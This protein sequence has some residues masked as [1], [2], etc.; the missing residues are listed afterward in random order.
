MSRLASIEKAGYFPCPER[1]VGQLIRECTELN[2]ANGCAYTILDPCAGEG[3]A[4]NVLRYTLAERAPSCTFGITAVELDQQRAAAA[5]QLLGHDNVLHGPWENVR[6]KNAAVFN[7]CW[8]NPPYDQYA[9]GRTEVEWVQSVGPLAQVIF[10]VVPEMFVGTGKH[11]ERMKSALRDAG[12]TSAS[13]YRFPDP[14]YD[15]FHQVI[16][17]AYKT[18]SG[19]YGWIDL[20]LTGVIGEDVKRFSQYISGY[21]NQKPREVPVLGMTSPKLRASV[22]TSL[23][24]DLLGDPQAGPA[25]LRPLAPMRDTHAAAMAAAGAFNGAPI[26][27]LVVK[28][29]TI[30][31]VQM[32]VTVEDN[33]REEVEKEVLAAQ[34]STLNMHTGEISTVNSI[35]NAEVFDE[36]IMRHA[37]EFMRLAQDM[38][39]PRFEEA[40]MLRY[41][42]RLSHI[43]A[44]RKLAGRQNGVY[45]A[46]ALRV[47]AILDGWSR[48]KVITL[49]GKQGVGK[50]L[51]ALAACTVKARQRSAHNQ[52]IVVLLPAKDD[53]ARKWMEEAEAALKEYKPYVVHATKISEVQKAFAKQGLVYIFIKETMAKQTSGW[54]SVE[55]TPARMG[56][57]AYLPERCP[58]CG[59]ALHLDTDNPTRKKAHCKGCSTPMWT[60]SRRTNGNGRKKGNETSLGDLDTAINVYRAILDGWTWSDV[61]VQRRKATGKD[62]NGSTVYEI[63]TETMRRAEWHKPEFRLDDPFYSEKTVLLHR[64]IRDSTPRTWADFRLPDEADGYARH[65]LARYIRDHYA[66]QYGL[67]IDESHSFKAADSARA[68]A[69]ND[70]LTSAAFAV[71]MTGT[72][73]NGMA[74][75]I[76]YLLWRA[77][78]AFRELWGWNDV[79]DFVAKYGLS[80]RVTTSKT[81]DTW[82]SKG[83]YI[84][85]SERVEEIPG[86]HPAMIGLLLPTTV[87]FDLS[88]LDEALPS[89]EE[90]TLFVPRPPEMNRV[91][92]YLDDVKTEAVKKMWEGDR[93]LL[94]QWAWGQRGVWDTVSEGDE[95]GDFT[96]AP[97]ACPGPMWPKEE[98]LLRFIWREKQ[99]GRKVLVYVGQINRRDPTGKLLQLMGRYGIKADV[100]RSDEDHRVEFMQKA[101]G[102]GA[103]AVM[104][105]AA[106]V[107]EGIDLIEFATIAWYTA[108]SNLYLIMQANRRIYRIGQTKNALIAYFAYDE[109]PQ[110]ADMDRAARKM[111]AAQMVQG[112][113]RSGLAA[114]LGEETFVSR[115]QEAT[116]AYEHRESSLTMDDLPPLPAPRR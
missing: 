115:L 13:V 109:T 64:F 66:N 31:K 92:N 24:K 54:A 56:K 58:N 2:F 37:P 50:T 74:S 80:Q 17:C 52:K 36:M 75:S 90:V 101:L 34:L 103:D 91:Q 25:E 14:E 4:V 114:I 77:D 61:P 44:P 53:L 106:L 112:D 38:Y 32:F 86:V 111:G 96:L 113:M 35:D 102:S 65:P 28:G 26:G 87:F 73:Y 40:D 7:L 76:Y 62:A 104:T 93:S 48:H 55:G 99:L 84:Q 18:S 12:F 33:V 60:V 22:F 98:A 49:A 29:S 51:C 30:K 79:N 110:A 71:Q 83:G 9:G 19:W 67:V 21:Y 68:L 47:G 57:K 100:M 3:N 97:I 78:P 41:A 94:G 46:Q 72:P 15:A 69:S 107:K 8:L 89:Y 85:S 42:E 70:L 11:A 43:H 88:D 6:R 23:A 39:P 95:M 1:V 116:L 63:V 108:E 81:R 82:H 20:A 5:R 16:I 27:D 105:S 45:P 10:I 59:A